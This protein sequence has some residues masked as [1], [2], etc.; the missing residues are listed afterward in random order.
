MS[1]N[2]QVS[3]IVT[4]IPPRVRQALIRAARKQR[5]SIN[6]TAVRILAA[7][8]SIERE[9]KQ[10]RFVEATSTARMIFSVPTE[11]RTALRVHAAE[12][13]LTMRGLV[14]TA[15]AEAYGVPFK[16][17]ARRPRTKAKT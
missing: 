3:I 9:P 8:Y 11:V 15:L 7:H 17:A 5:V 1:D 16:S 6:E 10:T 14:I 13:G 2:G 4:D 12:R